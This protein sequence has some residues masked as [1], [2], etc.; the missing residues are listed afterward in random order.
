MATSIITCGYCGDKSEKENGCIN[1]AKRL[2][3][4]IYCDKKCFG[5]ASRNGKSKTQLVE[6]KRLYDEQYRNKNKAILKISKAE[7]N[8]RTYDP[9]KAA[10]VRKKRAPQHAEYCRQPEYV[11][12]KKKYDLQ[13]RAKK[14]HGE[15]WESQ[16]LLMEVVEEVD[17]RMSKYE[18]GLEAGTLNKS[19][20]R[21]RHERSN[22]T[23]PK[24]I[25]LGNLRVRPMRINAAN[26]G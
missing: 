15:F 14:T 11:A 6:D 21:K 22:S 26:A 8:R 20:E 19:Q 24:E 12:W 16:V 1:R 2:G 9:E 13:Y 7:Y 17:S 25:T 3:V 5:F 23:K 4:P 18:I 10:V